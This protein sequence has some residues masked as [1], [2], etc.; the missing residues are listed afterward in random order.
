[1]QHWKHAEEMSDK[2][3]D[4]P[5]S[6]R[7]EILSLIDAGL[8]SADKCLSEKPVD[9][10]TEG[11]CYKWKSVLL[12]KWGD[13]QGTKDKIR[14]SYEV[15]DNAVEACRRLPNDS[16]ANHVL[17]AFY[18]HVANLSWVEKKVA[19][20][21][22]HTVPAHTFDE[23]LPYLLKAQEAEPTFIRNAL[24][25]GDTEA[26]LGHKKEAQEWYA[27]CS[28]LTPSVLVE[29]DLVAQCRRKAGSA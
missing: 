23:A 7:E 22:F 2:A 15:R 16:V 24:M 3:G 6:R 11:Q 25:I 29:E 19:A 20:A 28:T 5:A 4:L 17:G 1:M 13:L 27:R 12:S 14:N 18:Y 26:H 10:E 9:A 21:L 8:A